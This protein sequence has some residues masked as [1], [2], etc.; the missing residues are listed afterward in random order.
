MFPL[1][2]LFIKVC[3]LFISYMSGPIDNI[4]NILAPMALIVY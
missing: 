4:N 1:N 3:L 2:Y